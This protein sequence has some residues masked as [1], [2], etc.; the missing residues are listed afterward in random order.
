M[1]INDVE[2]VVSRYNEDLRWMLESPFNEFQYTVYNKGVN[3]NFEKSNV[4]EIISLPNVGRCDHTFLYHIIKN[5]NNL[6]PITV[7]FPGSINMSNKKEKAIKILEIIKNKNFQ[8]GAF[9]GQYSES[10]FNDFELFSM[11]THPCGDKSNF[12]LNPET[13]LKPSI[14]RPYGTWYKYHFKNINVNI[15]TYW[16]ILSIHKDDILQH[17]IERYKQLIYGTSL[18]SNPEVTHYI[19]RSWGAIFHPFRKTLVKIV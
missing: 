16:G 1:S 2:I 9:V 4:K 19:E 5:Y 3:E 15:Y 17:P 12:D 8:Y 11:E 10:I 6:S 7:F 13:V 14:L 18:H